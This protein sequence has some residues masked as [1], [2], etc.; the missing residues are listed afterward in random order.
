MMTIDVR[1]TGCRVRAHMLAVAMALGCG[2]TSAGAQTPSSPPVAVEPPGPAFFAMRVADFEAA[3]AWYREVLDLDVANELDAED[4]GYSIQILSG[5]GL[6]VELIE[7]RDVPPA[8]DPHLGLFKAGIHVADLD[9]LHQRL[10]ALGVDADQEVFADSALSI[11]TFVF[12]DP[13]GNRIQAFERVAL[14]AASDDSQ[15]SAAR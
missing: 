13:E 9:G 14:P 2:A 4:G 6:M 12:R 3:S 10:L 1:M 7:Q 5:P 8:S 11:R 15:G